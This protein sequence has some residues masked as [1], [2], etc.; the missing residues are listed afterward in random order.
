MMNHND[1]LFYDGNC[2]FC[3]HIVIFLL[4]R[5]SDKKLK[6]APLEGATAQ[7]LMKDRYIE[8]MTLDTVVFF[9]NNNFHIQSTAALMAFQKV[10]KWSIL[11][12]LLLWIPRFL[13]DPIYR[14]I[15][16]NRKKIWE[17]C[18]IIPEELKDAFLP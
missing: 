8:L 13:R 17:T 3:N 7:H 6:F 18:P 10:R 15:A 12:Q 14:L 1:I 9:E 5:D 4:K 16:R 11:A 2:P